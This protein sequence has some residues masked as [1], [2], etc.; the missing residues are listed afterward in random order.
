MNWL[1]VLIAP[2]V[3]SFLGVLIRRLPRGRPVALDRSRCEGCGHVLGPRELIPLLSYL[4]QHGRCR[5]CGA[6]IDAFHPIIELA[7]TIVAV[8]AVAVAG[9]QG[10]LLW[11]DVILGWGLMTLAWIDIETWRLPDVLTLPLL[12]LGL[13]EALAFRDAFVLEDRLIAVVL[14]WSALAAVALLYRKVR[15]RTGLGWGDPKLF[16][17]GCAWTGL[18]ELPFILLGAAVLGLLTALVLR[19]TGRRVSA[20]TALPFGPCL[21]GAIWLV[22]LLSEYENITAQQ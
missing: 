10:P 8:I 21:A 18:A 4:V 2:F 22:R 17:A 14:G 6:Q 9:P 13:G 7:T 5:S 12:L 11:G 1:A 3:G 16:A 20:D 19:I 15:G